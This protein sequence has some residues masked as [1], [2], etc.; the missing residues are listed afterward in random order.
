MDQRTS[1][2]Q[3]TARLSGGLAERTEEAAARL[4]QGKEAMLIRE[5]LTVYLDLRDALGFDFDRTIQPLRGREL[6]TA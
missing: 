4:F 6:A 1:S 2:Y 3:V 5:A